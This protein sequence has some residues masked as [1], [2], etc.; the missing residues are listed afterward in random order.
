MEYY[1]TLFHFPLKADIQNL[2]EYIKIDLI[3]L[4]RDMKLTQNF[5]E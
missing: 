2:P 3:N 1:F 4:E 5:P